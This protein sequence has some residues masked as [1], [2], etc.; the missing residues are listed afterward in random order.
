MRMQKKWIG[1]GC[2]LA[3]A[4]SAPGQ[5]VIP[6][7]AVLASVWQDPAVVAQEQQLNLSGQTN[8]QLPF[9]EQIGLRTETDRFEL[10]REE[11]LSRV[12]VNGLREIRAQRQLQDA[13]L[14]LSR[15]KLRILRH[16]ALLDRYQ[17]LTTCRLLQR[18]LELQRQLLLVYQDQAFVLSQ[19]AAQQADADLEAIIKVEYDRDDL[20]LR[21]A[22]SEGALR[23]L[24]AAIGQ[25]VAVNS[26]DWQLDTTGFIPASRILEITAAMPQSG[27]QNPELA[28]GQAKMEQIDA[29]YRLEK[30]KAG[31]V[32]DFFQLRYNNRPGEP[33]NRD[34]SVGIGLNIPYKGSARIKRNTLKIEQ[35][36]AGLEWRLD[37]D[38]NTRSISSARRKLT[39][40]DQQYHL[41]QQLW[42]DS[43]ARFT[44]AQSALA[45][46]SGPLPV[47]K[48]RELQLKRQ[49]TLLDLES[50]MFG[51][52]LNLLDWTGALSAEPAINYLSASLGGY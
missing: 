29:A 33:L 41:A 17:T 32:L 3:L 45:E 46:A 35:Q 11:Y 8:L 42:Q 10:R 26:T 27:W 28:L 23:E 12:S 48:A 6:G 19:L 51:Q 52:Y 43:Q 39:A 13:G 1:S 4:L 14:E 38:E 16:K 9:V 49:F 18:K 40:L 2:L 30:A 44:L 7:S 21:V 25:W 15:G 50:E 20:A 5:P 22:A 24:R 34:L 31:Q 37:Q 47:L 36:E